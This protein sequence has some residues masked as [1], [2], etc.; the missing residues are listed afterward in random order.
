M[1]V[2][3][4]RARAD[5]SG[6]TG[7]DHRDLE[8]PFGGRS[9]DLPGV[10]PEVES[11]G[12]RGGR[13]GA[14]GPQNPTLGPKRPI[15]EA[16]APE[17]PSVRARIGAVECVAVIESD[18]PVQ[19][20]LG[21]LTPGRDRLAPGHADVVV[22]LSVPHQRGLA[23]IPQLVPGSAA[24]QSLL[25]QDVPRVPGVGRQGL[26][27]PRRQHPEGLDLGMT[28]E[29]EVVG[30]V[31][32]D[33]K[34]VEE[35]PGAPAAHREG[36]PGDTEG[37][38]VAVV[39]I[40][41]QAADPVGHGVVSPRGV[42]AQS[43]LAEALPS[44]VAGGRPARSVGYRTDRVVD[45]A[46]GH[47]LG[48]VGPFEVHV[49][50]REPG[51]IEWPGR[52]RSLLPRATEPLG[53][54]LANR[55]PELECAVEGPSE[56]AHGHDTGRVDGP[57][58]DLRSLGEP[59]GPPGERRCRKVLRH[60]Q[61]RI[62]SQLRQGQ[63]ARGLGPQREDVDHSSLGELRAG[64]A[65]PLQNERVMAIVVESVSGSQ[66]LVHEQREIQAHSRFAGGVE[67][68]VLVPPDGMVHPVDNVF[69]ATAR[70]GVGDRSDPLC[71][72]LTEAVQDG[73][74]SI[75]GAA[76]FG[77][78]GHASSLRVATGPGLVRLERLEPRQHRIPEI[79]RSAAVGFESPRRS[80][81]RA[82]SG[83]EVAS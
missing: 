78:L 6:Q 36:L 75:G 8:W 45:W 68:G 63:G 25:G 46:T 65:G 70:L 1:P 48:D 47:E 51:P 26:V 5:Q 73:F 2:V 18:Q 42:G 19:G 29:A 53:Q 71:Q 3:G 16:E 82:P 64:V 37:R 62:A 52:R 55:L 50:E 60:H 23:E 80:A 12:V 39:E 38:D 41:R 10:S 58:R 17:K 20:L 56:L 7:A 14:D 31:A 24:L 76:D 66:A 54:R 74:H 11:G 30:E 72:R 79:G 9:E 49:V 43:S 77:T 57:D 13:S 59:G 40:G 69:A 15:E 22:Q 35:L 83:L 61:R 21:V 28:M 4:E 27:R 34:L 33:Q 32:P 67:G 81:H 44:C